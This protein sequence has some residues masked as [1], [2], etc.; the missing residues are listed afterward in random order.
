MNKTD[1]N[2]IAFDF[3]YNPQNY[4]PYKKFVKLAIKD[5]RP[6]SLVSGLYQMT[7]VGFPCSS[8]NDV[9]VFKIDGA[10]IHKN[11]SYGY[12]FVSPTH[13]SAYGKTAEEFYSDW[14]DCHYKKH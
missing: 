11:L 6:Q 5:Y 12:L 4:L 10:E 7:V 8:P 13:L 14:K 1:S 3:L 2:N 9:M